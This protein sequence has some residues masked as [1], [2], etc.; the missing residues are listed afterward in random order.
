MQAYFLEKYQDK[1]IGIVAAFG[2]AALELVLSLRM[3]LWA[4]TPVIFAAVDEGIAD[5][6]TLPSQVTGTTMPAPLSDSA[7]VARAIVP[8]LKRIAIV[9]DP[10]DRQF[11]RRQVPA[12]LELLWPRSSS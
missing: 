10:P 2:S 7:S 12:Q 9:G 6:L 8:G 1:P 5:R 4:A 3:Q 11:I